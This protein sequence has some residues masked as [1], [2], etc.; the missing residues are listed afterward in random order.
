MMLPK[1][2]KMLRLELVLENKNI[3]KLAKYIAYPKISIPV[4]NK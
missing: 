1:L 4:T 3:L 2:K